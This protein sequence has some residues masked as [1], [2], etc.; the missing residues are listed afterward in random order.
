M[1]IYFFI[2]I[3]LLSMGA[4]AMASAQTRTDFS[5]G[6]ESW[7]PYYYKDAFDFASIEEMLK[8][9]F[10]LGIVNGY[11]YG[12]TVATY[13]A[14]PDKNQNIHGVTSDISNIRKLLSNRLDGFLMDEVAASQMLKEE[15]VLDKIQKHPVIVYED[16]IHVMFS[17]KSTTLDDVEKINQSLQELRDNGTYN[18][19]YR[20]YLID[21]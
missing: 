5:F 13:L 12:D 11:Y 4:N 10:N 19:I 6:W 7:P 16:D 8:S 20:K 18:R 14:N 9:S 21:F 1:K 3:V 17:K 2:W 15:G